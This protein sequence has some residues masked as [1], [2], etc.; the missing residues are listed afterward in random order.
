MPKD[1]EKFGRSMTV[2]SRQKEH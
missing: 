1:T 2:N